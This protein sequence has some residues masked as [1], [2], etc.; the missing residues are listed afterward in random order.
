MIMGNNYNFEIEN[1]V[2][3]K[4]WDY[5]EDVTIPDNVIRIGMKRPLAIL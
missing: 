2:L 3:I 5:K 1:G 4:Y